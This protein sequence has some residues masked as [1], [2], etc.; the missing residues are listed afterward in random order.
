M[1]TGVGKLETAFILRGGVT[2]E[3]SSNL[4]AAG[5]VYH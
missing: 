1:T 2:V 4:V 5:Q 3:C